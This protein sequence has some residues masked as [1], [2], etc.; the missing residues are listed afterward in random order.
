[1]LKSSSG[2]GVALGLKMVQGVI[3]IAYQIC[4]NFVPRLTAP[5]LSYPVQIWVDLKASK[6]MCSRQIH[7]ASLQAVFGW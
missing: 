2:R 6:W 5:L 4:D 3:F 7:P 1:L